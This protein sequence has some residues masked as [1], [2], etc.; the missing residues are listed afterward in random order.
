[1]FF[2]LNVGPFLSGGSDKTPNAGGFSLNAPFKQI[3]GASMRRIVDFNNLNETRMVLPTG[4]SGIHNSPH[5]RDQARLF[6]LG[7]Y[8]K[9]NFDEDYIKNKTGY[10]HMAFVPENK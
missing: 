5:Y 8:R 6:H 1:M 7:K 3:A 4:Q 2:D 9:S 10:R